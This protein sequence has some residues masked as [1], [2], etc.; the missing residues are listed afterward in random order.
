MR[1]RVPSAIQTSPFSA[2]PTPIIPPSC[3]AIGKSASVPTGLPSRSISRTVPFRPPIQTRSSDTPVPQPTPSSPMPAK[4]VIGGE[5]GVPSG[6]NLAVPPPRLVATPDCE[7][8]SQ[9]T[10]LQTLPCASIDE[11]ARRQR[12]AAVER[13]RQREVRRRHEQ[14]GQRRAPAPGA[15]GRLRVADWNKAEERGRVRPGRTGDVGDRLQRV[16]RH[17]AA[18]G[19]GRLQE[20]RAPAVILRRGEGGDQVAKRIQLRQSRRLRAVERIEQRLAPGSCRRVDEVGHVSGGDPQAQAVAADCRSLD[21]AGMGEYRCD[22]GQFVDRPVGGT[23]SPSTDI[24]VTPSSGPDL[25]V[26]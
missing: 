14:V 4:P 15:G 25:V 13:E 9:L 21:E 2:M 1:L 3:P 22:G 17:H 12:A 6:A 18:R 5:S 24:S 23:L 20:V 26:R 7:P 10:P 8:G 19:G 11:L 16:L